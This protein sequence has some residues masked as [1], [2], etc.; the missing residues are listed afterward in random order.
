MVT[1]PVVQSSSFG[2]P[3][4]LP[5]SARRW[6]RS[7]HLHEVRSAG[8]RAGGGGGGGKFTRPLGASSG[9]EVTTPREGVELVEGDVFGPAAVKSE[10][11]NGSASLFAADERTLVASPHDKVR[12][13]GGREEEEESG[14][15]DEWVD[16]DADGTD[17][18]SQHSGLNGTR[19]RINVM[20]PKDPVA[21]VLD[22]F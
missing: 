11:G 3:G 4:G 5:K 10:G 20:Q 6:A 19:H 16:T 7:A 18:E 15:A 1:V 17:S 14:E 21:S 8:Y 22:V 12:D 13:G 2:T 9:S